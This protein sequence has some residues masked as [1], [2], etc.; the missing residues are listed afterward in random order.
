MKY[1]PAILVLLAFIAALVFGARSSKARPSD[2]EAIEAFAKVRALRIV[3]VEQRYNPWPYWLRG[4]LLLS[5]MARIF[6][7]TANSDEGGRREL[8]VAFDNWGTSGGIQVL[9]EIAIAP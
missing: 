7:V 1:L 2:F 8:H 3:S 9:R 5:N 6:V 4:R